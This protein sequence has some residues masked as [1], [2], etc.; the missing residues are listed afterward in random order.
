MKRLCQGEKPKDDTISVHNLSSQLDVAEE[1]QAQLS[2]VNSKF[3]SLWF[4]AGFVLQG[5]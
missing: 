3:S 1:A 4:I 5:I 2:Q